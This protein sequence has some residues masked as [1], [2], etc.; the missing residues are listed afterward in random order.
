VPEQE[1]LPRLLTDNDRPDAA[2]DMGVDSIQVLGDLRHAKPVMRHPSGQ[3][4]TEILH[5]RRDGS[6]PFRRRHLPHGGRQSFFRF[7]HRSEAKDVWHGTSRYSY[8]AS[9][10]DC[11]LADSFSEWHIINSSQGPISTSQN[12]CVEVLEPLEPME[13]FT[14]R[15]DHRAVGRRRAAPRLHAG[16][17]RAETRAL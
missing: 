6:P 11:N 3:V 16:Q 9:T 12:H 10:S 1:S 14:M 7:I 13:H 17:C 5:A 2:T 4:T 8:Q 15:R